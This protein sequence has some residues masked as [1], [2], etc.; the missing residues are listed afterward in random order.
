MA[1]FVC[2]TVK[3]IDSCNVAIRRQ[4]NSRVIV[5]NRDK[6][7][8]VNNVAD[9]V[10][11]ILDDRCVENKEMSEINDNDDIDVAVEKGNEQRPKRITRSPSRF[12]QAA[13]VCSQGEKT[14]WQ[15]T[16]SKKCPV[17]NKMYRSAKV[18]RQHTQAMHYERTSKARARALNQRLERKR[19]DHVVSALSSS[20]LGMIITE[21][22]AA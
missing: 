22:R 7:R 13:F 1:E 14:E 8:P 12:I 9:D 6:L 4:C 19:S 2:R 3:L 20:T 21:F 11:R 10:V 17:R 5:V 15:F 16:A 18:L